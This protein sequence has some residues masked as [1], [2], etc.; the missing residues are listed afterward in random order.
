MNFFL[1]P[2][3]RVIIRA[4]VLEDI[5]LYKLLYKYMYNRNK[6]IVDFSHEFQ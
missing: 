1:L 4:I 5:A 6:V 2:I 3:F